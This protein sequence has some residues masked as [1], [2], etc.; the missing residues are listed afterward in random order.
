[1]M[2]NKSTSKKSKNKEDTL[3]VHRTSSRMWVDPNLALESALTEFGSGRK[4][5]GSDLEKIQTLIQKDS[6]SQKSAE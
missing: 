2:L 1:M 6:K 4:F 3:V 5:S